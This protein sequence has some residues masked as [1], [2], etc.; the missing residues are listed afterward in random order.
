MKIA[1]RTLFAWMLIACSSSNAADD[2]LEQTLPISAVER[3]EVYPV[4]IGK[5]ESPLFTIDL[6]ND[7]GREILIHS[8][9]LSFKG[10]TDRNDLES[11]RLFR[12][13]TARGPRADELLSEIQGNNASLVFAPPVALA[14]GRERWLL[15]CSVRKEALLDHRVRVECDSIET[16]AGTVRPRLEGSAI[17]QRIGIALRQA[18]QDG[19]H[20]FR[21]P[22]L[23]TTRA[24]TLLCAYDVRWKS[25][26]DLQGDIDVGLSRSLDRGQTWLPTQI[27]MDMGEYGGRPQA[28]NGIGDPGIVVDETTGEVFVFALWV[29]AKSGKHQ[30]RADGSEPG[31]E[32]GKTAQFML[33]RSIDDGATWSPVENITLQ[34]KKESWALFAPS[35]NQGIQLR[36]GTLVLPAQGRDADGPFATIIM[37]RDHGK[38]WTTAPRAYSGGNECQAVERRD[39]SIML[40]IRNGEK[41]RRGVVITKDL[42]QS[43]ELHPTHEKDLLEPT[44]NASLYRWNGPNDASVSSLLLFANP[45]D[46]KRRVRQTIRMSVDEGE[47]WPLASRLLLDEEEGAGYPSL[48][49]VDDGHVGIV[50]EG[51]QSHLVFERI[52]RQELLSIAPAR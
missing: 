46:A 22:V 49:R 21:I 4:L 39:G 9:R 32:I 19:V 26:R 12:R 52:S 35:P 31:F 10:T 11:V 44:C 1:C 30:W 33:T 28:E 3:H 16:S 47:T 45:A 50:Y 2:A 36:D 7:T 48:S 29:H 42:G 43:W 38:T 37:S 5:K 20:T 25:S 24:G 17:A 41:K 23:A 18:G 13:H 40:N 27:I 51:S 6:R 15:A 8:L 14:T 34:V